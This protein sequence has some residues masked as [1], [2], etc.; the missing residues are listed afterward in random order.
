M[1]R[2]TEMNPELSFHDIKQIGHQVG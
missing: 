2:T 1:R